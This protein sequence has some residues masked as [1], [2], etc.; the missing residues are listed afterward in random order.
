MVSRRE[1]EQSPNTY[2]LNRLIE[3]QKFTSMRDRFGGVIE[4]WATLD[5]VWANARDERKPQEVFVQDADR[6][7]AFR[8]LTFR[9]RWRADFD[10]TARVRF[11]GRIFDIK[12][13]AEVGRRQWLD[14]ITASAP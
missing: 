12:G 10:E 1:R 4:G 11:E 2:D 7:L 6:T 9:V 14:I 13:L 5:T 8:Y 3:I